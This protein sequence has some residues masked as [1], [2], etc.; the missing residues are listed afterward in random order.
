MPLGQSNEPK[1][2]ASCLPY[3]DDSPFFFDSI[4]WYY[5]GVPTGEN[6]MRMLHDETGAPVERES[7]HV[8]E[9]R[10]QMPE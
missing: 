9:L 6:S 4:G 7:P 5:Q 8:P 2:E 1:S 10:P 3:T